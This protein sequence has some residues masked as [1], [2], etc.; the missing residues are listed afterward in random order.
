MDGS[1]DE[2]RFYDHALKAGEVEVLAGR[3][4]AG[5]SYR[6][7]VSTDLVSWESKAVGI[8]GGRRELLPGGAGA[9][10]WLGLGD[11]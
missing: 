6:V 10:R 11:F 3:E 7:E 1:L 8:V 5:A 2:L 4:E 9:L